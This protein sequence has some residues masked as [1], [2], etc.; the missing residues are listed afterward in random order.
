MQNWQ[1]CVLVARMSFG[2][3]GA[4]VYFMEK[5]KVFGGLHEQAQPTKTHASNQT[6]PK[7]IGIDCI[8]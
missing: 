8:G 4:S 3:T 2:C 5:I 7:V 1:K 6:H